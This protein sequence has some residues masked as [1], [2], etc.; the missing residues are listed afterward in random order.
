MSYRVWPTAATRAR[1]SGG[2]SV[3]QPLHAALTL[4]GLPPA[5]SVSS[6]G[7]SNRIAQ[8]TGGTLAFSGLAPSVAVSGGGTGFAARPYFFQTDQS[9]LLASIAA[10]DAE[11][12]GSASNNWGSPLGFITLCQAAVVASGATGRGYPL[13]GSYNDV[14]SW[15]LAVAGSLMQTYNGTGN[16]MRDS[17]KNECLA[18][19]AAHPSGTLS[20]D[21]FQHCEDVVGGV[22]IIGDCCYDRFTAGERST[23]A[24]WLNQA[25]AYVETQN[26]TFWPGQYVPSGKEAVNNN[27][28]NNQTLAWAM[29][30]LCS[31]GWNASAAT[32]R[33]HFEAIA[34]NYV[35][36]YNGDTQ[37]AGWKGPQVSEGRY[38]ST[39]FR[40]PLWAMRQYDSVMGTTFM[41]SLGANGCTPIEHLRMALFHLQPRGARNFFDGS[42]P[43]SSIAHV[44]TNG[45]GFL[46]FMMGMSDPSA[47]ETRVMKTIVNRADFTADSP[48]GWARTNK[49]F[50]NFY[51]NTRPISALAVASLTTRRLAMPS[52]GAARTFLRSSGGWD[53][54]TTT[55]A[56]VM[57]SCMVDWQN[58]PGNEPGFSHANP[59]VPGFQLS[60]GIDRVVTDVEYSESGGT[61]GIGNEQASDSAALWANIVTIASSI[62]PGATGWPVQ[63]FNED[64]TGASVPHYYKSIDAQPTW[65]QC[66][67]YRREYVWLDDLQ[68]VVIFDRVATSGSNAKTFRLH[69]DAGGGVTVAGGAATWTTGSTSARLRDLYSTDGNAM[70]AAAPSESTTY[71]KGPTII[72]I[73]QSLTSNDVRSLKVLDLN[74]RC[75][76]ASLSSGAGYLQADMTINGVARSVR[77]F[78]DGSHCT[79]S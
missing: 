18:F 67:I 8:P 61:A 47:T 78:D 60:Q 37:A 34:A 55:R 15:N 70:T 54:A 2:G 50:E 3:A 26:R 10:G 53:G 42:E 14:P 74:S 38:Y 64:N 56:A 71:S 4:A 40:N 1:P 65:T 23:V 27:Y 9:R 76:A 17:A 28:F 45:C 20:S 39:Y 35:S 43:N 22:A 25:I 73:S 46:W 66:T 63:L 52:P 16:T 62:N 68:V 41:S 31:E 36:F 33:A 79:V 69:V 44:A 75:S 6:T 77:F 58:N 32:H 24:T 11:A 7:Q 72:R 59:D 13:S 57:F 21:E 49:G 12:T 19:V 29:V 51:W 48:V 30:G 5:V